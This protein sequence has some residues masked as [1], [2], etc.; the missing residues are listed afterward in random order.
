MSRVRLLV[1]A[2]AAAHTVSLRTHL[3]RVFRIPTPLG[4]VQKAGLAMIMKATALASLL[5]AAHALDCESDN[6]PFAES[7]FVD[8]KGTTCAPGKYLCGDTSEHAYCFGDYKEKMADWKHPSHY[9]FEW[10]ADQDDSEVNVD[11]NC[12]LCT[13]PDAAPEL[14]DMDA[15]KGIVEQEVQTEKKAAEAKAPAHD[16]EKDMREREE[17]KAARE[18]SASSASEQ[19]AREDAQKEADDFSVREAA[20]KVAEAD[21]KA[22]KAAKVADQKANAEADERK[23]YAKAAKE[24]QR[25]D[26]AEAT[27][28]VIGADVNASHP[29]KDGTYN[30]LNV[31]ESPQ[32]VAE[33][34][35]AE[36]AL[37]WKI[38]QE[39]LADDA[40]AEAEDAE[41]AAAEEKAAKIEQE[42]L[43]DDAKA[44]AVHEEKAA[45]WRAEKEA[46]QQEAAAAV[47]AE[48]AA[49]WKAEKDA[50]QQKKKAWRAEKDASQEAAAVASA[51][52]KVERMVPTDAPSITEATEAEAPATGPSSS[53]RAERMAKKAAKKAKKSFYITNDPFFVV[54]GK[55]GH[56]WLPAGAPQK[57]LSVPFPD[58]S[59]SVALLGETFGDG[60]ASQWFKTYTLAVNGEHLVKVE[61]SDKPGELMRTMKVPIAQRPTPNAN[62][63]TPLPVAHS[64]FPDAQCLFL[65]P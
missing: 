64:P 8:D 22:E 42:D 40:K 57:L 14:D 35:H 27:E 53:A 11:G 12:I 5:A 34:K 46:A 25:A 9:P 38:E 2:A 30:D 47:H 58:A 19:K 20:R 43:A 1:N 33:R 7:R 60:E 16:M 29:Y 10:V 31:D 26:K 63:P 32:Q 45:A 37:A 21:L 36:K 50:A 4:S 59:H 62:W 61:V 23:A 51:E 48:K 56:F 6:S 18:A 54:N 24:V 17:R 65:N 39:D 3:F 49:A 15:R 28:T 44:E 55:K 41:K 52:A 13:S